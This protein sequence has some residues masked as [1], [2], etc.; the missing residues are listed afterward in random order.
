MSK[1]TEYTLTGNQYIGLLQDFPD[2]EGQINVETITADKTLTTSDKKY[3]VLSISGASGYNVF[4]PSAPDDLKEFWIYHNSALNTNNAL[5]IL[6]SGDITPFD[7]LYSNSMKGW[8][9][10]DTLGEW[11]PLSQSTG[12]PI[13]S[14]SNV[15]LGMFSK[16]SDSQSVA[17][18]F[19]T[20]TALNST[21]VGYNASSDEAGTA[22]GAATI[23]NFA[24]SFAMGFASSTQRYGDITHNL[25]GGRV[26]N[27]GWSFWFT[28]EAID[29]FN[30][31][32][33]LDDISTRYV[34]PTNSASA[35]HI[36]TIGVKDDGLE[37]GYFEHY[38]LATNV[39]G[40]VSTIGSVTN[41]VVA[42]SSTFINAV[43]Q[44]N[45]TNKSIEIL[46][47]NTAPV[48]SATFKWLSIGRRTEIEF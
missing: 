43:V 42:R 19:N 6:V 44:S 3:Q 33:F 48:G 46:V 40:T 4:L 1:Y 29:A 32:I 12:T 16:A 15:S 27:P 28:D 11:V 41:T 39:A 2:T 31:E 25:E 38:I 17:L 7:T 45:N 24:A 10:S 36:T 34:L 37:A 20:Q 23:A 14:Q 9:Y 13:R 22:I 8:K 5:N 35:F 30:T 18:G 21:S 26:N 47:S